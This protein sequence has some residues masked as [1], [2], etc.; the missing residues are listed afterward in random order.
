MII[1]SEGKI[2]LYCKGADSVIFERLNQS[3]TDQHKNTT[4]DHLNKFAGEGLRTLCLAKKELDAAVYERWR[5]RYHEAVTSLDNREEKV[6]AV[7]EE[8][9]QQLILVG[10]TAIEDKLQDGVPQCIANLAAANIKLWVLTGDKQETAINIGYSCQLLTD[11]MVDI[12]TIE[13]W[14]YDEVE[15][16]LKRCRE[17]MNHVNIHS[18]GAP[19]L[20]VVTFSEH[21]SSPLGSL[22]PPDASMHSNKLRVSTTSAIEV[23]P[24]NNQPGAQQQSGCGPTPG[25]NGGFALVV[26]GHSLVQ[27]LQ[28]SMELL[29]LEVASRCKAVICCRVT[30]LQKALVVDLVKR[31]K[32]AVTLAIGDG[33]NDVSMIKSECHI[34]P[35]H[36]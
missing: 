16:E 32:K 3:S 11:E 4:L 25:E 1:R 22:P 24:N 28:P 31:H 34:Y 6:S 20:S 15:Q 23:Q 8:I 26:N 36:G 18:Q 14:E 13:G 10:T 21:D 29:F 9:E 5:E 19:N 17:A 7:Y 12:F 2:T 33:A 35:Y 30:P 27:A